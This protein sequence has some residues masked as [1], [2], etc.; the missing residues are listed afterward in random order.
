MGNGHVGIFYIRMILIRLLVILFQHCYLPL[1]WK[2]KYPAAHHNQPPPGN[3]EQGT[4][5]NIFIIHAEKK[6][7]AVSS[8]TPLQPLLPVAMAPSLSS[9]MQRTN[10]PLFNEEKTNIFRLSFVL[11]LNFLH[12]LS[13]MHALRPWGICTL[14]SF[15]EK[16]CHFFDQP[17]D[18]SI[19][20]SVV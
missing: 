7:R 8:R 18:S 4:N 12:N 2:L 20:A 6:Q 13:P 16:W 5:E 3:V 1:Q 17:M 14:C 9:S 15:V 11:F 19:S 10:W